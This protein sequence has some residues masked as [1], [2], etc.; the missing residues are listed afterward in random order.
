[1]EDG[2]LKELVIQ[3]QMKIVKFKFLLDHFRNIKKLNLKDKIN[4]N[5]RLSNLIC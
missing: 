5:N 2:I 1:M 3:A 4:K